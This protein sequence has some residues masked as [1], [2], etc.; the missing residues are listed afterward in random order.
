MTIKR[1][2]YLFFLFGVVLCIA[3]ALLY[4]GSKTNDFEIIRT[5]DS[6]LIAPAKCE[7]SI[8]YGARTW[9]G[10]GIKIPIKVGKLSLPLELGELYSDY[11]S[12]QKASLIA[13][14]LDSRRVANCR[15]L[16]AATGMTNETR[17]RIYIQIQKDTER[18]HQLAL[19]LVI[20]KPEGI[21]N[22]IQSYG[23]L[24]S[25]I[26]ESG[27]KAGLQVSPSLDRVIP[28]EFLIQ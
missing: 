14:I 15:L 23:P 17:E 1:T 5:E 7:K 26:E 25:A 13:E 12:I 9:G 19:I 21:T 20:Q 8:Q 11:K 6:T 22:W 24:G 10:K 28:F 27:V 2:S 3:S 4:V 16:Q 18:I